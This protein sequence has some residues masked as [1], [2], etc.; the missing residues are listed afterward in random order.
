[1]DRSLALFCLF[2][3]VITPVAWAQTSADE[4]DTLADRQPTENVRGGAVYERAPGRVVDFAR[5]R[6]MGLRDERLAAQRSGDTSPLLPEPGTLAGLGSFSSSNPLLGLISSFL[7]TGTGTSGGTSTPATTGGNTSG[8][9]PEVI[10]M[11]TSFGIDLNSLNL[12]ATQDTDAGAT[13]P[14][15]EAETSQ[16]ATTQEE[17]D[18]IVRWADAMVSTLFTSLVL[19]V[20]TTDFIELIKDAFRPL[21]NM[22]EADESSDGATSRGRTYLWSGERFC[23]SMCRS[24]TPS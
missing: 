20:Q 5:A 24:C 15:K 8:L 12:R 11:L 22:E 19:A 14:A 1:M 3:L 16:A 21:L 10:Q 6:H 4:G 17:R 23:R 2:V 18:F 13:A 7:N 9:P